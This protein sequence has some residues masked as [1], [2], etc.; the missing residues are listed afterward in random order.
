MI[1]QLTSDVTHLSTHVVVFMH[2]LQEALTQRKVKPAHDSVAIK[3]V[4]KHLVI[5]AYGN[6]VLMLA[7]QPFIGSCLQPV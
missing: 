4:F 5:Y 6:V 7:C 1:V 2:T 3:V